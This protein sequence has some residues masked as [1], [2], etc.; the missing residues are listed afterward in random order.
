MKLSIIVMTSA[1]LSS[2]APS[3]A[4]R[5]EVNSG[6]ATAAPVGLYASEGRSSCLPADRQPSKLRSALD[7]GAAAV[8]G[9]I[10]AIFQQ[11][12]RP[13]FFNAPRCSMC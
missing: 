9:R 7:T 11:R 4:G 3:F 8:D 5:C 13:A 6:A 2:A 1:A 10:A 12:A